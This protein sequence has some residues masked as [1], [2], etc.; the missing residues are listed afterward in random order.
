MALS[1]QGRVQQ[2][3]SVQAQVVD[4]AR[5]LSASLRT[6]G[7]TVFK[8]GICLQVP[9]HADMPCVGVARHKPGLTFL[10]HG[11]FGG[12]PCTVLFDTGASDTF[13]SEKWLNRSMQWQTTLKPHK[14]DRQ[15]YATTADDKTV[16]V[17]SK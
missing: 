2:S 5:P 6:Q 9:I 11:G 14:L 1:A 15:I 8:D 17:N 12:K 4:E 10:F 7:G 3:S 16:P 13:V